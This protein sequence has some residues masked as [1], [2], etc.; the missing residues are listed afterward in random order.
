[1]DITNQIRE[2]IFQPLMRFGT[3]GAIMSS[4]VPHHSF[5]R[6]H[7]PISRETFRSLLLHSGYANVPNQVDL[8]NNDELAAL[9]F[10]SVLDF[11]AYGF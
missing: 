10:W 1:M 5:M 3:A 9:W 11:Y 2:E 6:R 8:R 7:I 4:L